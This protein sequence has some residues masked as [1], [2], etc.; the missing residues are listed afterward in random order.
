MERL[1]EKYRS[2]D[3][4]GMKATFG[5]IGLVVLLAILQTIQ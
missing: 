2:F 1:I 5:L 3:K 4:D